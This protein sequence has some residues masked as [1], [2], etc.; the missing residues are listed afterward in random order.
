MTRTAGGVPSRASAISSFALRFQSVM[1]SA[2][3]VPVG[4][5]E[6]GGDD[7]VTQGLS[8]RVFDFMGAFLRCG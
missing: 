3:A 1:A 6:R 4:Q 2:A 8:W 7:D 5:R